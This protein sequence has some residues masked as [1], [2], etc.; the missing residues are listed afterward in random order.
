MYSRGAAARAAVGGRGERPTELPLFDAGAGLGADE[1]ESQA[2]TNTA[3]ARS[4]TSL[5]RVV[6]GI[7]KNATTT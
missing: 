3:S 2:A 4:A 6:V 7:T 1:R 5:A